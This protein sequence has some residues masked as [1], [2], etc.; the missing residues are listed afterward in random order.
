MTENFLCEKCAEAAR[1]LTPGKRLRCKH[2]SC[3]VTVRSN[4]DRLYRWDRNKG[5]RGQTAP[6]SGDMR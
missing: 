5:P 2:R 4:G 3:S 1:M 6:M